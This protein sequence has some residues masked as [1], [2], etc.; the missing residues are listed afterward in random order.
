AP[1]PQQH[2]QQAQQPSFGAAMPGGGFGA[3]VGGAPPMPE[4]PKGE[5]GIVSWD[6]IA[7]SKEANE[8]MVAH[9]TDFQKISAASSDKKGTNPVLVVG[10][11]LL[12]VVMMSYAFLGGEKK[13]GGSKGPTVDFASMET[14][15]ITVE[16]IGEADCMRQARASYM[17]GL[18]L[19][20]KQDVE[21]RNLFDGYKRM[22]ET[23]V[24]LEK[25]NVVGIPDE[26]AKLEST[27]SEARRVLDAKFREFQ[28]RYHQSAQRQGY[29]EMV[30]VLNA[31]FVY[32]PDRTA[33][34]N[35]WA[36]QREV[37]MKSKGTYP[38]LK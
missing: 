21:N 11:G 24:L 27:E 18:D 38:R 8:E 13:G 6:E 10:A 32:F 19:I 34:E 28:M 14:V 36:V 33:R 22:R 16:C 7:Q 29:Q 25:G 12:I 4:K 9:A 15:E 1:P 30:G 3:P 37:D 2:Q 23:R 26:M 5:A 20:E 31:I 35:R 17:R